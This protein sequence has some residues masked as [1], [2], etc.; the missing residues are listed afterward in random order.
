MP[1]LCTAAQRRRPAI[2]PKG[3]VLR[4]VLVLSLWHAP[5][6]WV[7]A[8]EIEGP[9]VERL[10]L[11]AEH[12]TA[13][14]ARE[15]SQGAR[16]L[17]WHVHLMLPWCFDHHFPCPDQE[18]REPGSDDYFGGPALNA[19]AATSAKAI[20]QP[21]ARAFLEGYPAVD[22]PAALPY[23]PGAQVALAAVGRMVHF[24]ETYARPHPV[25]DLVGVRLC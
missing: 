9:Q 4:V 15:L 6:P 20:G 21:T 5:I 14:H 25:R 12:V 24:F 3:G 7:H 11:L 10:R 2:G 22:Q 18:Q 23:A 1:E 17:D 16:R 19:M 8:H 13:F